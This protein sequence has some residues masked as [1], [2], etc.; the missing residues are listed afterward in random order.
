MFT[1]LSFAKDDN[2]L[3]LSSGTSHHLTVW[4]LGLIFI[5]S[6]TTRISISIAL[7]SFIVQIANFEDLDKL[8]LS[9]VVHIPFFCQVEIHNTSLCTAKHNSLTGS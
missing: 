4:L 1:K 9:I 6:L 5:F 7:Q 3:L 2:N 8:K